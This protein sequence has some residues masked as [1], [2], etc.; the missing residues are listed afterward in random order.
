MT[1]CVFPLALEQVTVSWGPDKKVSLSVE[2]L[3][4]ETIRSLKC[5]I[6]GQGVR[7]SRVR[8]NAETVREGPAS[9]RLHLMLSLQRK[10][11][12]WNGG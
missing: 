7:C 8:G 9:S 6:H 3:C 2:A 1:S 10:I 5:S 4:H 12:Q 11:I